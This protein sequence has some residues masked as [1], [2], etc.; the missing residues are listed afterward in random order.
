M[1]RK[2]MIMSYIYCKFSISVKITSSSSFPH[3]IITSIYLNFLNIYIN[4][5]K[6]INIYIW[7]TLWIE[8][9]HLISLRSINHIPYLNL[10]FP[11]HS[12][13]FAHHNLLSPAQ[14]NFI[15][16]IVSIMCHTCCDNGQYIF[17]KITATFILFCK[18]S[19]ITISIMSM[20]KG[21]GMWTPDSVPWGSCTRKSSCVF[22]GKV[23][24]MRSIPWPRIWLPLSSTSTAQR[25]LM[26]HQRH[27]W[28]GSKIQKVSKCDGFWTCIVKGNKNPVEYNG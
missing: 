9:H 4:I 20:E 11:Y 24:R 7:F 17:I 22:A 12:L 27:H 18:V 23:L 21:K 5:L 28:K 3:Y 14:P 2:C 1:N 16:Q 15:I 25:C 10:Q 6:I 19:P 13:L 26:W 8:T